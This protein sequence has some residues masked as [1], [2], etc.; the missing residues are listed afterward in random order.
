MD[1]TVIIGVLLGVFAIIGGMVAKGA[2]P[3]ALINPAAPVEIIEGLQKYML[4]QGF[5]NIQELKESYAPG[6]DDINL[7]AP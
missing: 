3:A 6:R 7:Q 1:I 4:D 5:K 2:S